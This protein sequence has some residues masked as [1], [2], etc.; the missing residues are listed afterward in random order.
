MRAVCL[1]GQTEEDLVVWDHVIEASQYPQFENREFILAE[2]FDVSNTSSPRRLWNLDA[3]RIDKGSEDGVMLDDIVM[4]KEGLVG[5]IKVVSDDQAVVLPIDVVSE[6]MQ[7]GLFSQYGG[8]EDIRLT[9]Y[10]GYVD[11]VQ[12]DY[13]GSY[14]YCMPMLDPAYIGET[15]YTLGDEYFPRGILIGHVTDKSIVTNDHL[16]PF[17]VGGN[18]YEL[19]ETMSYIKLADHLYNLYGDT[20]IVVHYD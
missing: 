9:H 6:A 18:P 5:I 8:D 17:D 13:N 16:P 2:V 10:S 1:A 20:V 3:V 19:I 12:K 14:W 4:S 15:V 11:Y 7:F